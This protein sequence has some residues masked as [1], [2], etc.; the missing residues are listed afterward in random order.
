MTA[1]M[2][3]GILR[4]VPNAPKTPQRTV[5][6]PDKTWDAAK[7]TAER[8]GDNLSEVIRQSLERYVKRNPP[9]ARNVEASEE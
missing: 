9:P 8:R 7:A 5:R 1:V 4:L 3:P 2:T 6:I